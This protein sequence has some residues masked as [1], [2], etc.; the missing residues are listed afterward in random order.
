MSCLRDAAALFRLVLQQRQ[1]RVGR[2]NG[3]GASVREP[4]TPSQG[5]CSPL[6]GQGKP[7]AS[8]SRFLGA[9]PRFMFAGLGGRGWQKWR[10][11]A[12]QS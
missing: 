4:S 8:S 11:R 12:A 1:R 7:A 9:L 2:S 3:G 10:F 6:A 5:F